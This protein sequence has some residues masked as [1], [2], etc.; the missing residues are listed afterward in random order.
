MW[1][2]ILHSGG[3]TLYEAAAIVVADAENGHVLTR[4]C[5]ELV[6]AVSTARTSPSAS[7]R[8]NAVE[9]ALQLVAKHVGVELPPPSRGRG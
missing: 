9:Q 5:G 1:R 2:E 3:P 4:L 8:F 7:L 6:L